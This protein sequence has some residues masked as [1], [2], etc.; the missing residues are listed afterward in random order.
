MHIRNSA[1]GRPWWRV[2]SVL[3]A[4]VLSMLVVVAPPSAA[5]ADQAGKGGDFVPFPVA[6]QLLDTRDG[7]GG[8]SAPVGGGATVK[9]TALGRG[10]VPASGVSAVL[11]DVTVVL[12]TMGTFLTL[13]P[14]GSTQPALSTANA[15]PGQI[16]SNTAVVG[17]GSNGEISLYNN[18]GDTHVTVDVQG[19]FTETSG[20]AGGGFVA[21]DHTRLVDTRGSLGGNP[22]EIPAWGNKTF[23]LASSAP[24]SPVPGRATSVFLDIIV[25]DAENGGWLAAYPAG[26]AVGRSI[27]DFIPGT[28]AHGAAV[29]LA[30]N[31]QVTFAN[32]S[33]SPITLVLT[34]EGYFLP[35]SSEGAGLRVVPANRLIDTRTTASPVPAGQF[36]DVS[37]GGT[38]GLPTRDI[39]GAAFNL[40]VADPTAGGHL[41]VWPTGAA[42]PASSLVNFV[43]NEARAA[44]AIVKVGTEAKV[45]IRNMSSGTVH[46]VVDLQ[47]WFANPMPTLAVAQNT[48]VSVMQ[49]APASGA[50][51]G[52]LEY[53]YVDNIGQARHGRQTNVDNFASVQWT[54]LPQGPGFTGQP[55]LSQFT[56]GEVRVAAQN[57]DSDI[58]AVNQSNPQSPGWSA[59][60]DLGGS[61]A[62]PPVAV[63]LSDTDGTTVLFAVDV[64]G[65][66]WHR[67]QATVT[68]PGAGWRS[69]GDADLTAALTAVQVENGYQIFAVDTAGAVKTANYTTSGGLSPWTSLGG[70]GATGVPAAVVYPGYRL[71]VFV[72]SASGTVITK[73]QNTSGG[74]PAQWDSVGTFVANGAPAAILDQSGRVTV[75][76]RGTDGEVYRTFETTQASSTWETW[77]RISPDVSD[78]TVTDPTLARVTKTEGETWIIV[79]RNANNAVRVYERSISSAARSGGSEYVG[80]TLPAPPAE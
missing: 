12:P 13:W 63:K 25:T 45:R 7:T 36:I 2:A 62:S 67:R 41:A 19:Y 61:M 52:G 27:M 69:L 8:I 30:T 4:L 75:V 50:Q 31:G 70:T 71:R 49:A 65:R 21:M 37:V 33:G 72:R 17:I 47:G 46:V 5:L 44:F 14:A 26:G 43:A 3:S 66:L 9:F 18:A 68:S 1:D 57:L 29:K 15:M 55:A 58:W 20:G 59:W 32:N 39:A 42:E 22:G 24:N 53:A 40:T 60:A 10:G 80:H 77:L 48:R 6:G 54:A 64:D 56:S 28:T 11:V 51:L 38:N 78:P 16:L 23:T 79:Y 73:V 34:A 76:A 35:N 74:W